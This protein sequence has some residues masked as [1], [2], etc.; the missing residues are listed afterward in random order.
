MARKRIET[1]PALKSWDDVDSNLLEILKTEVAIEELE[2]ELSVRV[3]ELKEKYKK[4]TDPLKTKIKVL[5]KEMQEYT[6]EHRDDMGG[7]KTKLLAHGY[8]SFRKSTKLSIPKKIVPDAI[9][10]LK[11]KGFLNC[12][13]V[14]ESINKEELKKQPLELLIEVGA[15]LKTDDAFGYETDKES[16]PD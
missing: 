8:V 2:G 1:E 10:K 15:S 13:T 6:D 14:K 7:K 3:A 16:L 5:E 12:L 4:L 9:Q 11:S